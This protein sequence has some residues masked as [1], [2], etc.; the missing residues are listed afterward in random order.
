MAV[1]ADLDHVAGELLVGGVEALQL[2]RG[3]DAASVRPGE[4]IAIDVRDQSHAAVGADRADPRHRLTDVSAGSEQLGVRVAH[5]LT[6]D[7]TGAQVLEHRSPGQRVVDVL[8]HGAS[9]RMAFPGWVPPRT[10]LLVGF[11]AALTHSPRSA[12]LLFDIS[13]RYIG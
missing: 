3:G 8:P 10:G 9:V 1:E 7:A 6:V 12:I 13:V 2:G 5:V 4:R 11:S